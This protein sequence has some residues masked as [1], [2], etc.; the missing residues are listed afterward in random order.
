MGEF[1]QLLVGTRSRGG[2][3]GIIKMFVDVDGEGGF[4]VSARVEEAQNEINV[5]AEARNRKRWRR[6]RGEKDR[7]DGRQ[8]K[9]A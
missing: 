7:G 5:R 2:F 1:F 9:F 3:H 8:A 4:G 6:V